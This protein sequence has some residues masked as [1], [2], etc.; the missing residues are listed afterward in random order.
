MF[1]KEESKR[2]RQEFWVS[3]GKS[4]PHKWTLYNTKIKG[5]SFKFHF[6]IKR[7]MVSIDIDHVDLEKR[8]GLW[9]KMVSLKSILKEEFL[10]EAIFE[11]SYLLENHKEI[12]RIYLELP[13]VS[14]HNK[15]T[16]QQ[17]MEFLNVNMLKLED[18]FDNYQDILNS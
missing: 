10:P 5:F 18:F 13:N 12:S 16:W 6:E 2:L 1:S 9:E 11:D 4:F 17:T 14:I 15:N 3:F 8:I 7:A